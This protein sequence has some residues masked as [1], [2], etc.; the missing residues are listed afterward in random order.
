MFVMSATLLASFITTIR[1]KRKRTLK[2]WGK[3]KKLFLY[4]LV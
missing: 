1:F 4:Y 2:G 3:E